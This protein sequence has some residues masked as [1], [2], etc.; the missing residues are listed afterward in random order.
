MQLIK[1]AFYHIFILFFTKYLLLLF[2]ML[3]IFI[4][5]FIFDKSNFIKNAS[6]TDM[7]GTV[8][9]PHPK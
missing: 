6:F 4:F 1:P 8:S 3:K 7:D 2:I 9:S 5:D